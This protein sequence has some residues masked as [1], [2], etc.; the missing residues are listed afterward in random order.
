M[1]GSNLWT[2]LGSQAG[3][4]QVKYP[5]QREDMSKDEVW[6]R[7]QTHHSFSKGKANDFKRFTDS[8]VCWKLF[9][10]R[11]E[12]F[13]SF[14]LWHQRAYIILIFNMERQKPTSLREL[15]IWPQQAQSLPCIA[16]MGWS[17]CLPRFPRCFC[18]QDHSL[19]CL[20]GLKSMWVG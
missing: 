4:T 7:L 16:A 1:G 2:L 8:L 17:I 11:L 3:Q 13:F 19:W 9:S 14:V 6:L 10:C 5:R 15:W 12:T 18:H 20:L